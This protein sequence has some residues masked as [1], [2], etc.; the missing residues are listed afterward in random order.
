MPHLILLNKPYNVLC[1]FTDKEGRPTLADYLH[2]PNVYAAGRLD[3]DSEGLVILTDSG[4][5]QQQ[6]SEPQ[7]KMPKTYWAQ[8][9]GVPTQDVLK[10]LARGMKLKDGMTLPARVRIIEPPNVWERV[11][12][13]RFRQNIPTTWLELIIAEGRKRQVRRMTAHVGFPTL[14]L[15][16]PQVGE[17]KL[18]N[19]KPGEWREVPPNR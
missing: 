8:V 16:R 13:I 6:I 12:P 18:G 14:R 5:L 4:A 1:Q 15:I 17:W 9:E 19:L 7:F 3:Y 11:P 10:Q 2:V